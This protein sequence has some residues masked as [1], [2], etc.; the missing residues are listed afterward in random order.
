MYRPEPA[1]FLEMVRRQAIAGE[2]ISFSLVRNARSGLTGGSV[3]Y[4]EL[5]RRASR[6]AAWLEAGNA[7]GQNVLLLFPDGID[8]ICAFLGCLYA[9][10]VAV[11][12]PLPGTTSAA[13]DRTVSILRDAMPV[14]VLTD[15]GN[16]AAVRQWLTEQDGAGVA[17]AGPGDIPEA[18]GGWTASETAPDQLAFIQ[19]TSGSTS[20]P[21]GVM[22]SHGNLLANLES[23]HRCIGSTPG[24]RAV[25][26]LPVIHDMGLVGQILS[27]CYAGGSLVMMPPRE[28]IRYPYRWLSLISG[29]RA[30]HTVAPNFA[31]ELCVRRVTDEQVAT[32]NLSSLEVAM[33]GAEPVA[34]DTLAAFAER[35]APAGFRETAFAPCYGMAEATLLISGSPRLKPPVTALVD[36]EALA[37]RRFA[38]LTETGTLA[39]GKTQGQAGSGR[40]ARRL[41][42]SGRAEGCEVVIVDPETRTVQPPGGIGEIWVRGNSVARGYWRRDETTA[43][44]FGQA[45]AGGE[46]GYLRTGDLG[47]LRDGELFVT[48]RLKDL[49]IV[50]GRN[51]YPHDME[52]AVRNSD[53]RLRTGASAIFTRTETSEDIVVVQEVRSA[54]KDEA[55]LRE[56]AAKVRRALAREFSVSPYAVVLARPGA[57]QMTTSGKTRRALMR[58]SYAA[59]TIKSI[60]IDTQGGRGRMTESGSFPDRGELSEWIRERVAFYLDRPAEAIDPAVELA[61][62]GMDSVYAIS[63]I[64][65]IEDRLNEELDVAEI[66][67]CPTINALAGYLLTVA[68]WQRPEA[69]AT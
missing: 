62:Y 66:R 5:D 3:S 32:L 10:A 45:I 21:K 8:F 14:T 60:F 12:A 20:D 57:V 4:G 43:A 69:E 53:Q 22:V 9:G 27:V 35:F 34:A 23:I 58:G 17:C 68:V 47:A 52:Q 50:N 61:E 31:Y 40:P 36:M 30:T 38:E 19:Y 11:P 48:G 18:P 65:D 51:L 13:M 64:S 67:K 24:L 25:G 59:G 49:V 6:I 28:F 26:W 46:P 56:I 37:A 7:R 15:E 41:V 44:T 54:P 2:R 42:S 55:G 63:V 29:T 33:N 39:A 16:V 1:T